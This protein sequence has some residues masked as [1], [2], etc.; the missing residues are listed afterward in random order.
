MERPKERIGLALPIGDDLPA[1]EQLGLV[2]YAE[3]LGYESVWLGESWGR[4][5]FT[6]LTWLACHTST[7][8]LGVGI[9]NVFSR[10]PALIAQTVA[11]LDHLSGGRALLG[12]GA[13]GRAV[14]ENWHGIPF[15]R[16][17][18]R[19]KEYAEII[20]MA[21]SGE[22]VDYEGQIYK[23]RGFRLGVTPM[24]PQVL[25]VT[26]MRP[27][28]PIYF[29]SISPAG[30]R[31]AGQVADGWFPI[32][33]AAEQV[34]THLTQMQEAARSAGRSPTA[35][36]IAPGIYSA[37][38]SDAHVRDLARGH[39]AY[40]I[41]GMGVYYYEWV[42]R[43]GFGPAAD[44]IREAYAQR[45]RDRAASLVTD[46]MLDSLVLAGEAGKCRARLARYRQAGATLPIVEFVRGLSGQQIRET[47]EALAPGK[48]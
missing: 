25:G 24:R 47:V 11:T 28:V 19:L 43:Q 10:S 15:E 35:I 16:S 13:S 27:Q 30:I 21:L 1:E 36:D 32:W 12:L 41:G 6:T 48:D 2:Q 46:A 38:S 31:A 4:E 26:P 7:I 5:V 23:L 14:I 39:L 40:Y 9:A 20:R 3:R 45:E 17:I 8:K 44:A 34:S 18:Q 22:R 37:V 42:K 33:M 29:A